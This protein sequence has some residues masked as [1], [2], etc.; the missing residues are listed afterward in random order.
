MTCS[1]SRNLESDMRCCSVLRCGAFHA[2][3]C[4]EFRVL[5][6]MPL[7]RSFLV[8]EAKGAALR[9]LLELLFARA[10]SASLV[11]EVGTPEAHHCA[12][13]LYRVVICDKL[14]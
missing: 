8:D 5:D 10:S 13:A 4:H 12:E 6:R 11:Q 14:H 9:P 3:R 7:V 1:I 2:L